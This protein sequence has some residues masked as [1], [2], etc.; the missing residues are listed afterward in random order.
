V[1]ICGN[2]GCKFSIWD[3]LGVACGHQFAEYIPKT[4][5]EYRPLPGCPVWERDS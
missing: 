3:E 5:G 4:D 2:L 1:C